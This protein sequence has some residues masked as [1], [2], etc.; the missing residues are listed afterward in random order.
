MKILFCQTQFKLGGQQKVLLTLAR[1]LS[2]DHDVTIYYEN[3]NFFNLNGLK[4]IQPSKFIQGI[5]LFISLL[6]NVLKRKFKKKIVADYWH[7]KNLK[8]TFNGEEYDCVILLNPYIL[9]V[10]EIR[11]K[12]L[13]SNNI[14][15]W[16]HNLYENYVNERFIF[17]QNQLFNS[18]RSADKIVSLEEHTASKWKKINSNTIVIHNPVTIDNH[19]KISSLNNKSVAFVGRIQIDSKGIDYLCEVARKLPEGIVIN[20]AGSGNSSDE[21][22]LSQWI[23]QYSLEKKIN[24]LGVLTETEMTDLYERSSLLLMTSR[25]EGFPLVA[26]E[27]MSFGLPLIGF[28]IPSL[29]E[30]TSNG[31]YGKLIDFGDVESMA[32]FITKI[33]ND[34]ELLSIYSEKSLKRSK[35][36]SVS[37]IANTWCKEV[38][39]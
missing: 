30:V 1:E 31:E 39:L 4:T 23:E 8:S 9:F 28:D 17:E 5:N 33:L 26:V 37:S 12:I 24:L 27:A 29:K 38:L 32:S 7:L 21:N 19:G 11:N 18:M 25:Y 6:R 3:H 15:C 13:K 14:V 35:E 2:K 34:K 20:M 22:K 16:T 10:N 36:L